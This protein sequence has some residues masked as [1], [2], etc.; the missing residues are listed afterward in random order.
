MVVP[1]SRLKLLTLHMHSIQATK[2]VLLLKTDKKQRVENVPLM[3]L[4]VKP[5]IGA[6]LPNQYSSIRLQVAFVKILVE[7][8]GTKLHPRHPAVS[9]IHFRSYQKNTVTADPR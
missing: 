8:Q 4:A 1:R 6:P 5:A 9:Q 3:I 2:P 7:L